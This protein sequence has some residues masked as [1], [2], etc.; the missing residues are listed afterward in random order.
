MNTN[1]RLARIRILAFIGLFLIISIPSLV[2]SQ[3]R[4]AKTIEIISKLEL[5]E[6]VQYEMIEF[7]I[8]PLLYQVSGNDSLEVREIEK[9]LTDEEILRRISVVFDEKF[10]DEEINDVYNFLR[11]SAFEKF[12]NS[13]Q[14][15]QA[16]NESFKDFNAELNRIESGQRSSHDI[17]IRKFEPI[18]VDRKNGFY[19]IIGNIPSNDYANIDLAIEPAITPKDIKEVKKTYRDYGDQGAEISLVLTEEGSQKFYLLTRANI[20]K[21]IAIVIENRIV[22]MPTVN[23]AITGGRVSIAGDFS[24]EE[25]DRMIEILMDEQ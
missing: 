19:E 5:V 12:F 2:F 3:D 25:I 21:Q 9:Q 24:E 8:R 11:T 4:Q 13:G 22:L 1:R 18:P 16:I 23:A 20:A 15:Y 17:S 10:T 14:I 7:K 6:N